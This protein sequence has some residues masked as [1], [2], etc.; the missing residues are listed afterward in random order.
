MYCILRLLSCWDI[1]LPV[2]MMGERCWWAGPSETSIAFYETRWRRITEYGSVDRHRQQKQKCYWVLF[3]F[4]SHC[5]ICFCL[6]LDLNQ[7][8]FKALNSSPVVLCSYRL[9]RQK[10][11]A[12]QPYELAPH[13][14][15]L[16]LILLHFRTAVW[17]ANFVLLSV[18]VTQSTTLSTNFTLVTKRYPVRS[19]CATV[20]VTKAWFVCWKGRKRVKG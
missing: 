17:E 15:T 16:P 6:N 2:I 10:L 1:A 5:F 12:N 14:Q 13:H 7:G 11:I 4:H 3:F 8:L 19:L 18:G 9:Q 20:I